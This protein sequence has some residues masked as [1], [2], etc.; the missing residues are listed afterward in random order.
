[1]SEQ[2]SFGYE[3]VDADEKTRRVGEV[4]SNVAAKYDIGRDAQDEFALRS[5]QKALSAVSSG[6]F[7]E[8]IEPIEAPADA[9][10]R[11]AHRRIT[12]RGTFDGRPS[13]H[14]LV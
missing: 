2:V 9:R 4:F 13:D 1:M 7:D 14:R 12:H 6:R 11:S 3:T 10:G 8:E 5:H